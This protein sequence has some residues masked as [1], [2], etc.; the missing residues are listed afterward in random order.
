MSNAPSPYGCHTNAFDPYPYDFCGSYSNSKIP[1]KAAKPPHTFFSVDWVETAIEHVVVADIPGMD[2]ED[3]KVQMEDGKVLEISCERI[4]Q[5]VG[6]TDKWHERTTGRC[7]RRFPVPEN[8][9]GEKVTAHLDKGVLTV[10]LAK[11]EEENDK[12]KVV[13]ISG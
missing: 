6:V 13:E 10:T 3:V 7:S 4:G 1:E 8:A 5:M 12:I 2:K 9:V 11:K